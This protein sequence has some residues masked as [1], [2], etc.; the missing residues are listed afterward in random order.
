MPTAAAGI[1]L[2][3]IARACGYPHAARAEDFDS[4]DRELAAAKRRG[5]LSFLEAA[6]SLGARE[7]LGRPTTTALENKKS[8]M[9]YMEAL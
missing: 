9:A 8:F 3:S 4:L 5:E 2:V 1:N 7:D 6:C